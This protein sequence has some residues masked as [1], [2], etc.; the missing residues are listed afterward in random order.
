MGTSITKSFSAGYEPVQ[1]VTLTLEI[2]DRV[3]DTVTVHYK[4][5]ASIGG[6]SYDLYGHHRWNTVHL[7]AKSEGTSG[8]TSF[9]YYA[10]GQGPASVTKTGSFKIS[11][12]SNSATSVSIGAYATRNGNY[13]TDGYT[14]GRYGKREVGS[15]SC[16]PNVSYTIKFNANGGTQSTCPDKKTIYYAPSGTNITIPTK[17][18]K[19]PNGYYD[20][21]GGWSTSSGLSNKVN[22]K[23]GKKYLINK[24][25]TLYAV[26][27][28]HQYNYKF[29]NDGTLIS[30]K[31]HKYGTNTTLEK[32]PRKDG[33]T[34][35]I[36]ADDAWRK[37]P[38]GHNGWLCDADGLRYKAEASV[39]I[40]KQNSSPG[41]ATDVNFTAQ[42][43][44]NKYR[45]IFNAN[46]GTVDTPSKDVLY[47]DPLGQLPVPVRPG[48]QFLGWSRV[49]MLTRKD[50]ERLYANSD[51]NLVCTYD[52]KT[53]QTSTYSDV[54]MPDPLLPATQDMW[55][56]DYNYDIVLYAY[57]DYL[58]TFYVY[59]EGETLG[60]GQWH[61]AIPYVYAD[62]K[63]QM[64][65]GYCN[66][67]NQWKL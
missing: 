36:L 10:L 64:M 40:N 57:W 2:S 50:Q 3:Y 49:P 62:D 29:W 51:A 14:T 20:F 66:V 42:W 55:T 45:L 33:H 6:S 24:N 67:E 7:Y 31:S 26:W 43:T 30:T 11:G 39:N 9:R 47:N 22:Y 53:R 60:T 37:G 19:Y 34:F 4:Y 16:S 8:E 65:V 12:L 13:G 21:A 44:R 15:P 35:G 41:K 56:V 54:L 28:A 32:E 63:W 27:K 23:S 1:H 52:Y 46:G 25:D 17:K 59:T 48:Y 18:P 58:T 61:L 38:T 5:H